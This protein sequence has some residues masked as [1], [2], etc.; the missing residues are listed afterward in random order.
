MGMGDW[1][2]MY[3]QTAHGSQIIWKGWGTPPAGGF[4]IPTAS[5]TEQILR[6]WVE[7]CGLPTQKTVGCL[8]AHRPKPTALL[9]SEPALRPSI[10]IAEIEVYLS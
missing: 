3:D 4:Y 9:Q 6:R 10:H 2:P 8:Y 5:A 1:S 7:M